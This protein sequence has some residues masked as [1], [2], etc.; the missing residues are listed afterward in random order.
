MTKYF[1]PYCFSPLS[2]C[3]LIL[4]YLSTKRLLFTYFF[5]FMAAPVAYKGSRA[6]GHIRATDGAYATAM[7][8][9]DLKCIYNLLC[10]L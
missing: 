8:T 6:R 9:P 7:V 10:S 5:L 3:L 4:I 2:A 1:F